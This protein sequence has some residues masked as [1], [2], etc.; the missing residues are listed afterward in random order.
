MQESELPSIGS[1]PIFVL[2]LLLIR[3]IAR[4][5]SP[6][7]HFYGEDRRHAIKA[8]AGYHGFRLVLDKAV[9]QAAVRVR[10]REMLATEGALSMLRIRFS[11]TKTC[12]AAA[13]QTLVFPPAFD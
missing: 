3:W 11:S 13:T 8:A 2:S 10:L 6:T 12:I 9:D 4:R 5:L 7:K 1:L